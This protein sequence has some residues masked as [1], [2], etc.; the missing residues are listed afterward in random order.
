VAA[1]GSG[2][3]GQGTV[4]GRPQATYNNNLLPVSAWAHQLQLLAELLAVL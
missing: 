3:G 2:A 4:S 1:Q